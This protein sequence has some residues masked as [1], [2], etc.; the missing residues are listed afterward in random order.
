M[1]Y[2]RIFQASLR[3]ILNTSAPFTLMKCPTTPIY[4]ACSVICS[5]AMASNLSLLLATSYRAATI[6]VIVMV[7]S[8]FK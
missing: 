8:W 7:L 3:G 1:D 4:A 2:L 5:T 6:F